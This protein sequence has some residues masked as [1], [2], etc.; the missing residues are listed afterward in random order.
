M[1]IACLKKVVTGIGIM[2]VIAGVL[3][4]AGAYEALA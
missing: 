2:S 4:G 3:L 1:G